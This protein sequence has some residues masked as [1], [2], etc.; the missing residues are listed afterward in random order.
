MIDE[1]SSPS[2]GSQKR[3]P[4]VGFEHPGIVLDD[5]PPDETISLQGK[6]GEMFELGLY[7]QSIHRLQKISGSNDDLGDRVCGRGS[8]RETPLFRP[9]L[10]CACAQILNI[11]TIARI[12]KLLIKR[13]LI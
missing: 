4:L 7:P 13:Y 1:L 2:P 11:K 9:N 12:G 10:I 6:K 5:L 8:K 3:E